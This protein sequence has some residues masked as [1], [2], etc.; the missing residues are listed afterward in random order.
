MGEPTRELDGQPPRRL[1]YMRLDDLVDADVNPK[2]HAEDQIAGSVARFGF[3]ET[4]V[5]DE[6]TGKLVAGHGRRDELR[7]LVADGKPAPDGVIDDNG[8]WLVP[9]LRGWRSEN[10]VE[11]LA[12]GVALNRIGEAGGWKFDVLEHA[13]RD[14]DAAPLGFA[15]I[16]FDAADLERITADVE[17]QKRSGATGTSAGRTIHVP[18]KGAEVTRRGDVWLL[19]DHRIM[20]GDCRDTD[21]VSELV[22]DATVAV[23]VTSPPYAEQRDYDETSGFRP[24][25]PDEYV[26]WFAPVAANV[27]RV[28][29]DDGSWFVNIKPTVTPDGSDT[30]LYVFDLVLA[31]RRLWG[32][33]FVTEFCWERVGVPRQVTRRFKNQYEPVY[34]FARGDRWKIRPE[35]VRMPSDKVPIPAGPGI[36]ATTWN[37][38]QGE[39]GSVRFGE[40][41]RRVE[42]ESAYDYDGGNYPNLQGSGRSAILPRKRANP[43]LPFGDG[44][45]GEGHDV[46]EYTAPGFAYPGNRL[47]TFA[48]THDA[49]GHAAAFPVGLPGWF[50]RA[51]SD[52]GDVA[53]DPFLGSGS[54]VLAAEIERRVGLGMELS[55][56]YVDVACAR[57]QAETGQLPVLRSTG[58]PHDFLAATDP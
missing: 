47:P 6:R 58:E 39:E 33:H 37:T 35:Q 25:P 5:I 56:G 42:G 12:A 53:Y 23:A 44:E 55:P 7:R 3:I 41:N 20:C 16:G 38:H 8:V 34:Q 46:G 24:I 49:V 19:G 17:K 13:L 43:G 11:A 9:T 22:G 51:Y 29:A 14:F 2:D 31:H 1:E 21:D 57:W 15:G 26:D 45:Q 27:A 36:G 10:D 40:Q 52:R 48:G 50:L 54:T 4:P 32:W 28:L 18:E 30:E